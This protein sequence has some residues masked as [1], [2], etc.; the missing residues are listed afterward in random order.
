[1]KYDYRVYKMKV[2]KHEFGVAESEELIAYVAQ[3][4]T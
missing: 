4:E 3:G 1:M 2:E